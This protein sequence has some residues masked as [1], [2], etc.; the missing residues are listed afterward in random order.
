VSGFGRLLLLLNR[1][2]TAKGPKRTLR[3]KFPF[4]SRSRICLSF[5]EEALSTIAMQYLPG[6]KAFS[7]K[8]IPSASNSA[9][10]PRV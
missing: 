6:K 5:R 3:I 10:S 7:L 1:G 2:A 8:R 9:Q 4:K